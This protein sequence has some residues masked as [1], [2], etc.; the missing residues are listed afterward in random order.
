MKE[1]FLLKNF[2]GAIQDRIPQ[3]GKSA[4]LL[5]E[6]LCIEKEAVYRRLRGS[7]PFSFQEVYKIALHLGLSL[8]SIAVNGSPDSKHLTMRIIE[9]LEPTETDYET[10]E[11]FTNSIHR[12]K[13]DAISESGAIGSIIPS[14][15]CVNYENIY[16]FYLFKWSHQFGNPQ[17]IRP[18]S[19][20][21]ASSRLK[22]INRDFVESVY[23]SPKSIYI[24]D[25]RFIEYFV[26]DVRFFFDIRLIT[27]EDVNHLKDDLYL[28]LTNLERFAT[29]GRFDTGKRV[30]IFLANVHFDA[31]YNYIDATNYKLTMLRSFAFSDTYS[32]DEVIFNNMK[33]WIAFLKRTSTLISESNTTERIHF[34][35]QQRKL[36]KT[37]L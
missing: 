18:Y 24:F 2:I 33:N 17:K 32:F 9:Y 5:A 25:R 30:E 31:N 26:N 7:V 35:E 3:R 22:Q 27:V 1:D 14:S 10:I 29:Y 13:E 36:L 6:I 28:L 16:Q 21:K 34:F 4:E 12:L 23:N 20:T 37:L 19:E 8:V 11:E 15:L